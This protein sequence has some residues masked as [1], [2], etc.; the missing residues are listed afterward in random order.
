M[1][2]LNLLLLFVAL[3]IQNT[4]AQ[5]TRIVSLAPSLTEQLYLIG[6]QSKLVGCTSYC[7]QAKKDGKPVVSSA[8]D[9]N[10]ERVVS[11]KP[12]LVVTSS[13]TKPNTINTLKKFGIK[14]DVYPYPKS[15]SDLNA[16]FL[17]LAQS[18]GAKKEGEIIVDAQK[19]RLEKV[20]KQY[21]LLQ[22]TKIFMEIGAKP[23]FTVVPNTFMHDYIELIGG[24]NIAQHLK[25]GSITREAVILR[26]PDA[27]FV[28]T[29]GMIGQEEK[30]KWESYKQLQAVK[31]NQ[32]FIIDSRIASTPTPKNFVSTVETILVSLNKE[33]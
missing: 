1:K 28:V 14:V 8:I 25:V 32:V 12:T 15:F 17:K 29:M 20:L 9:V 22:D 5:E 13:L 18:V 19:K 33:K 16:Q 4:N 6:A 21:P 27:I 2:Y 26:N 31:K 7:E 3:I 10:V 24:K 11:L 23:L 30:Q